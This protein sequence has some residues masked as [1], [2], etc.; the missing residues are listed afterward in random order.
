MTIL[1]IFM[2]TSAPV[3]YDSFGPL[4][5]DGVA[6]SQRTLL[7]ERYLSVGIIKQDSLCPDQARRPLGRCALHGAVLLYGNVLRSSPLAQRQTQKNAC[8]SAFELLRQ[9]CTHGE[10]SV[11]RVSRDRHNSTGLRNLL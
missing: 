2:P 11:A 10:H 7:V 9:H 5:A 4:F 8:A 1:M 3:G 6:D